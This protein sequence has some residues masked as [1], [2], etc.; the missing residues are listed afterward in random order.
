MATARI[1]DRST[2]NI[3]IKRYLD[4]IGLPWEIEDGKRH[5][6][7]KISGEVVARLSRGGGSRKKYKTKM[8][9]DDI[10]RWLRRKTDGREA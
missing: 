5:R 9:L 2:I 4:E 7:V 8:V 1:S 10:R 6:V 3:D